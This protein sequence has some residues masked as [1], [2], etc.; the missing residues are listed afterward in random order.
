MTRPDVENEVKAGKTPVVASP[1]PADAAWP[2][3]GGRL[4]M[5]LRPQKA[6]RRPH[7][8]HRPHGRLLRTTNFRRPRRVGLAGGPTGD[9]G[10][11]LRR[12]PGGDPH[13]GLG[14]PRTAF[15]IAGAAAER[16]ARSERVVNM[17]VTSPPSG[18]RW[19]R[20]CG[21]GPASVSRVGSGGSH[22]LPVAA[23]AMVPPVYC[24]LA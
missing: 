15:E 16:Y 18:G 6:Q 22:D 9:P 3:K 13:R 7:S 8:I 20:P 4:T 17:G 11:S 24:P 10:T 2:P 14:R 19:G 21:A 1:I 23:P 12:S 5:P